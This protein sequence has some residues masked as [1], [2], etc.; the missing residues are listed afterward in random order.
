MVFRKTLLLLLPLA[1]SAC[2]SSQPTYSASNS[3][4]A[5]AAT[6]EVAPPPPAP[7]P[8]VVTPPVAPPR[9]VAPPTPAP[10][11]PQ[12]SA[13]RFSQVQPGKMGPVDKLGVGSCDQYIERYR[14]CFNSTQIERDQKFELRRTLGQQMRQ[15]KADTAA[16]RISKVAAACSDAETT[17]RAAF[18]KVGCSF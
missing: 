6:P 3:N 12:D 11:A 14:T 15:W 8:V 10:N 13:T 4:S 16:G 18:A 5:P 9:E 17:A 2:D 1:L 7:K